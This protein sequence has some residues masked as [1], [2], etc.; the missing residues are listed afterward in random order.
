MLATIRERLAWLAHA[1]LELEKRGRTDASPTISTPA[2]IQ[3][4]GKKLS[5]IAYG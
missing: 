2:A 1:P 4:N 5:C 3:I